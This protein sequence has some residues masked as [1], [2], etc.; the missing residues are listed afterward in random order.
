MAAGTEDD[1]MRFDIIP[2]LFSLVKIE[3]DS[4]DH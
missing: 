4:R 2:K 3:I 1:L